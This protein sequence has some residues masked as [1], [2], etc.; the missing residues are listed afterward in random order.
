MVFNLLWLYIFQI[1]MPNVG[2]DLPFHLWTQLDDEEL[3]QL[4]TFS[5]VVG[6][7]CN[8]VYDYRHPTYNN[9]IPSFR[10][11]MWGWLHKILA[12]YGHST[13]L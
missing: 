6:A 3:V 5:F 2:L 13:C 9:N 4:Y 11:T 7:A 1:H 8:M 12:F 10:P